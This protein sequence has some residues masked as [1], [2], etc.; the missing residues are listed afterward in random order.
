MHWW[1]LAG[2]GVAA[3]GPSGPSACGTFLGPGSNL[4]PRH[5]QADAQPRDY[6]GNLGPWRL[7]AQRE[8]PKWLLGFEAVSVALC[9]ALP[10]LLCAS[11]KVRP[12]VTSLPE[13][14]S[15][16]TRTLSHHPAPWSLISGRRYLFRARL[17]AHPPPPPQSVSSAPSTRLRQMCQMAESVELSKH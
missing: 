8:H 11:F 2:S 10:W 4:C 12:S 16:A 3:Q 6:N 17:P 13:R 7:D 15:P 14:Q 9:P 1:W 5:G